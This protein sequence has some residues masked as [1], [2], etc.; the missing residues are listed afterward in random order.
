MTLDLSSIG[1]RGGVLLCRGSQEM[2]NKL[3][4]F[5]ILSELA[6]SDRSAVY[7]ATDTEGDKTVALKA[8]ALETFGEQAAA[9]IESVREE[10]AASQVLASHNIALLNS[11]E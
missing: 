6:K 5:E 11:V 7:Q 10:A 8:I 1:L 4:R 9:V 3:G 2:S